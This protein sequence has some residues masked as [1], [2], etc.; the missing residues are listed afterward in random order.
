MYG[1]DAYGTQPYGASSFGPEDVFD[2]E[3]ML[4][5]PRADLVVTAELKMWEIGGSGPEERLRVASAAWATR[6]DDVPSSTPYMPRLESH[7]FK[8][9]INNGDRF[10]GMA[11]GDG[12]IVVANTDGALDAYVD[13]YAFDGREVI[14]RIGRKTDLQEH[15]HILFRGVVANVSA[16]DDKVTF[17][18]RDKSDRLN[19]PA[20]PNV[21]AG[22]GGSEGLGLG[23]ELVTNGTFNS[24]LSGWTDSASAYTWD[25]G[26]GDGYAPQFAAG[27]Y[28]LDQS[29]TTVAGKSYRV[30]VRGRGVS[31][32][33]VTVKWGGATLGSFA[34]TSS[35]NF[36]VV[37]TGSSTTLRIEITA[38]PGGAL[39]GFD[40]ASVRLI[41]E[42]PQGGPS[43]EGKRKPLTLGEVH[44]V[45][46][47]LI[48]PSLLIYQVHDH[49]AADGFESETVAVYDRGSPLT[50]QATVAEY[51]D[52]EG[53]SLSAGQA[54]SSRDGYFRIGGT[55]AGV[56]F[57]SV[58]SYLTGK[59][60]TTTAE[61]IEAVLA[62]NGALGAAEI[63]HTSF[64]VLALASDTPIGIH[65][66]ATDAVTVA[67]YIGTLMAGIG[68]WAGFNR[69][70]KLSVG[71][72]SAPAGNP[73]AYFDRDDGSIID[74]SREP[75]PDGIWPPPWRWR[76][77]YGRNYTVFTDFA[78]S[79]DN[80]TRVFYAEPYRLIEAA[81]DDILDDYPL[82]KDPPP[83]EAYYLD[84]GQ[85]EAEAER[86]LA[87]YSSG[88][89]LFR[90]TVPRTA[91]TL[92]IGDEINVTWP[93]YGLEAGRNLRIV[94]VEDKIELGE[95]G[96]G[97]SVEITAFG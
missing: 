93:R 94:S 25:S 60:Y 43:V 54:M 71:V 14:V 2:V 45:P 96:A 79:V 32:G 34:T 8:R 82:A 29:I 5:G 62:R 31:G 30:S 81:D 18:L 90:F 55:A 33:T 91:L 50:M 95:G 57:A 41:L 13:G 16:D 65:I 53:A 66:G 74:L 70:G 52:L 11:T 37:A 36:N 42:G 12:Q 80:T 77:A 35:S 20:Q 44:G 88:Y 56:V 7:S 78:G 84:L 48:D 39:Y 92:K 4:A 1:V 85:A 63:D 40:D 15:H 47:V 19:V 83:V 73:V 10:G 24:N 61:A 23:S 89:R 49:D 38:P 17:A 46:P 87:L 26:G 64:D 67:D 68:G 9:S 86:L 28:G 69:Q 97:I 58:R 76:V 3:A 22:T 72:F 21:Y 51:T 75:M 6:P 59:S 27:T